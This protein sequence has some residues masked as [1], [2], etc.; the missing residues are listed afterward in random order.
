MST[1]HEMQMEAVLF[2]L[3]FI[4]ILIFYKY[5]SYKRGRVQQ[6]KIE[7]RYKLSILQGGVVVSTLA[8][9]AL[10]PGFN[11]GLVHCACRLVHQAMIGRGSLIS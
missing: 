4:I 9:H 6:D 7:V 2:M 8:S 10:G 3:L 1:V 5:R 11:S